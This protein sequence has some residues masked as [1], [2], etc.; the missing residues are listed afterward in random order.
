ME[1][2]WHPV[3]IEQVV[4]RA[5]RICSH[6][7]LPPDDQ[8]VKVF[9][10]LLVHNQLLL[11][12]SYGSQFTGLRQVQDHDRTLKRAIS[13]DERLYMIMQNK[14][15]VME[16]FLT[17]LKISAIDCN[18]NYEDKSKCFSFYFKPNQIGESEGKSQ[19]RTRKTLSSKGSKGV[20]QNN[21]D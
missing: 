13:T 2:Y 5:R 12:G 17:S 3:R 18:L 6:K 21:E 1:P 19:V 9:M 15:Q 11:S 7:D 20:N 16:D 14:K 10:Y 8:T 4:G